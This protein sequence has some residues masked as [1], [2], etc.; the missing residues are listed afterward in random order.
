MI[1]FDNAATTFPK[2]R[3]VRQAMEM[4]MLK[5]GGNAGRGGHQLTER[6]SEQVFAA[7]EEAA[8]FFGGKPE[9]TIFCLNCTHA[10]NLAIQGI[11]QPNDHVII[12]NLEHNA[13]LRPVA[14]MVRER[15]VQ[16]S[17]A[18]VSVDDKETIAAFRARIRP[19]TRAII[20]TLASNVTGQ[21]LPYR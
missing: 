2:P 13:V 12:S 10:L 16:C 3:S 6:T 9:N 20:C 18:P 19:N 5:Y 4:A 8:A 21:I 14:A 17:I 1:N 7:R 11:V 15:G